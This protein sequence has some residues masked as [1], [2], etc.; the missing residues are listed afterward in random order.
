MSF[1]TIVLTSTT[2]LWGKIRQMSGTYMYVSELREA[3]V[4][5]SGSEVHW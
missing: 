2:R 3:P 4:I 5:V 1:R